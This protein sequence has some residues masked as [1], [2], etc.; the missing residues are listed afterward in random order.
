M[1]KDHES[2]ADFFSASSMAGLLQSIAGEPVL[3]EKPPQHGEHAHR[4]DDEG[5]V[6][7]IQL[8]RVCE[9][10]GYTPLYSSST[11]SS[12]STEDSPHLSVVLPFQRQGDDLFIAMLN[13]HIIQ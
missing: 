13:D 2:P 10:E 12:V 4:V 9:S 11:A 5:N 3:L 8:R 1:E 7:S 6:I